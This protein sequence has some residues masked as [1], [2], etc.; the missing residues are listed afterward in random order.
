MRKN[1]LI[2]CAGIVLLLAIVQAFSSFSGI[3]DMDVYIFQDIN[4]CKRLEL[5]DY[6]NSEIEY[7]QVSED[8]NY[9]LEMI[10][11]KFYGIRFVSDELKFDLFAY[12]FENGE[13][14]KEYFRR[15]TGKKEELD[16]N[17]LVSSGLLS[18]KVIAINENKAY[19]ASTSNKYSGELQT[20]LS[21]IFSVKLN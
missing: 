6:K 14:A 16:R 18:Y 4:E 5:L 10:A 7:Y 9:S 17:F 8:E 19:I 20:L 12:E 13:D 21:E 3:S 1:I 15:A 2:A 11:E